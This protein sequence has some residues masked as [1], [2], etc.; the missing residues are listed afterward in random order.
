MPARSRE[1]APCGTPHASMCISLVGVP[2]RLLRIVWSVIDLH[3]D[4]FFRRDGGAMHIPFGIAVEPPRREHDLGRGVFVL[5]LQAE[6]ELV[7]RMM[8]RLR[9][10]GSLVELDKG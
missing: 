7:R 9:N 8:M 10:A 1:P 2:G 5:A 6:H 4:G 3:H